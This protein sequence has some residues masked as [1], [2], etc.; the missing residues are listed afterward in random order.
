[1]QAERL[2]AFL[3]GSLEATILESELSAELQ[4]WRR[5]MSE[6][7]RSARVRLDDASFRFD[8]TREHLRH[9]LGERLEG[10]CLSRDGLPRRGPS[11]KRP[12]VAA[13]DE[14]RVALETLGERQEKGCVTAASARD[15][16]ATPENDLR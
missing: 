16:L 8:V 14:A 7:G 4:A 5:A 15:V 12:F 6:R 1:M 2:A 10:R 9:L 13:G 11:S 3:Q